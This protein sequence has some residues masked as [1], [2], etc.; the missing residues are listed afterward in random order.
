MIIFCNSL[1]HSPNILRPHFAFG[2]SSTYGAGNQF[3]RPTI[4]H[5]SNI[6]LE[7]RKLW[8][9]Y[10]RYQGDLRNFRNILNHDLIY[11]QGRNLLAS[12]NKYLQTMNNTFS[13]CNCRSSKLE[14]YANLVKKIKRRMWSFQPISICVQ[15]N[16]FN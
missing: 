1:I 8:T 13:L 11:K 16:N 12:I 2:K 6:Y 7:D 5:G 3:V 4:I 15:K 10:Q 14:H 9:N